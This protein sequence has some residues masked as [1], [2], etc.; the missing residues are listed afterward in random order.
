MLNL[1]DVTLVSVATKD[2]KASYEALKYSSK[3]IEFGE[4]LFMSNK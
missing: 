3:N 1:S 4:I 2:V